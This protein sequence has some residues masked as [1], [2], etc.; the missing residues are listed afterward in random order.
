MKITLDVR[1]NF[2]VLELLYIFNPD[3][4]V[5]QTY[6]SVNIYETKKLS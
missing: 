1:G 3:D 4:E 5:D 2:S 6:S